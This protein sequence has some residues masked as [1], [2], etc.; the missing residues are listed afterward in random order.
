MSTKRTLEVVGKRTIH[1]CTLTNNTRQATV[2]VTI[3]GDNMVL[4]SMIIFKGKHNRSISRLEFT[5]YP[6]GYH[7]CCQEAAWMDEW[8]MLVCVEEVLAPYVAMA[9]EDIIP[10]LILDSYQCYM[11]ASVVSKIQE[12]GVKV[13]HIPGRCTSPCQPVD[14]GFNKPFKS[15]VQKMWINWMIT[16]GVQEG[17]TSLP[18]RCNVAVWVDKAMA[19]MKEKQQIIKNA[20]LKTG[21][22]WFDKEEGEGVLGELGGMEGIV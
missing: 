9:P 14:E 21:F 5:T 18:T 1:I 16:K 17:T 2:T 12:L 22:E 3:A 11:M 20:W 8:V 19:K 6:A 4:P 7:Y 13:K 10:L 15:R